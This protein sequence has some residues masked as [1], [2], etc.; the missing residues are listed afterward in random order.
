M[1]QFEF[2]GGVTI[3]FV[4]ILINL[5]LSFLGEKK[6]RG[7][8]EQQAKQRQRLMKKPQAKLEWMCDDQVISRGKTC[9]T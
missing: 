8:L 1:V 2:G 3:Y 9:V 5:C 6:N 4:L 7:K